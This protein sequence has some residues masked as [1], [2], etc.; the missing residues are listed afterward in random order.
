MCSYGW[1]KWQ[2][3][4]NFWEILAFFGKTTPYGKMFKILFQMLSSRHRSTCYVQISWN[5]AD[6]KSVKSCVA[7]LTKKFRLALQ[8]SLYWADRTQN[9]PGPAPDNVPRVHQI[10]SKS[11]HFQ[12][13]YSRTRRNVNPIFGWSLASSRIITCYV[14]FSFGV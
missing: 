11:V 13:S 10:S 7:H 12:S 8:L 9:L 14:C 4:N 3:V 1:L 6:G 5:L 2:D